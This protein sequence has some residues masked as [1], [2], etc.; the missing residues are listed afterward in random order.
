MCWLAGFWMPD[1]LYFCKHILGSWYPCVSFGT[2][3]ASTLASWGSLGRS[4]DDPGTLGDTRKN[5]VR[6]RFAFYVFFIEFGDLL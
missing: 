4:L 1:S 5:T 2:L 3:V 6:P